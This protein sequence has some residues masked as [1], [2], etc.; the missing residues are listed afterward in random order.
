MYREAN[1]EKIILYQAAI[2]QRHKEKLSIKRRAYF[3]ANRDAIND[4]MRAYRAKAKQAGL[5]EAA[6]SAQQPGDPPA[7]PSCP[8]A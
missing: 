8:E 7:A 5:E 1:R 2:Y 6:A 4:R 3:L